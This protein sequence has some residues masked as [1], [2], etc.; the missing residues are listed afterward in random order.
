LG[1]AE[2]YMRVAVE[3]QEDL[4]NKILSVEIKE[5]RSLE[6]IGNLA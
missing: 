1:Y 2:N 5:A 4:K 3:S 6:A